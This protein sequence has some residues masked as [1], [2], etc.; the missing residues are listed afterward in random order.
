[1]IEAVDLTFVPGIDHARQERKDQSKQ[2]ADW[3]LD[4][5]VG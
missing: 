1:V 4:L 5:D 2:V 3:F